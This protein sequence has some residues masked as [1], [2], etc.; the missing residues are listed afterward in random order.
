[1]DANIN[2][3]IVPYFGYQQQLLQVA[4]SLQLL[5]APYQ[6]LFPVGHCHT[7]SVRIAIKRDGE[8]NEVLGIT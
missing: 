2:G 5:C 7:G 1:M 4:V 8:D 6:Q 3:F